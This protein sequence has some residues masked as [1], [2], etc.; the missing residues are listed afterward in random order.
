MEASD[1][2][3]LYES[4]SMCGYAFGYVHM[5]SFVLCISVYPYMKFRHMVVPHMYRF[6]ETA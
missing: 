3:R 4:M 1:I 5:F 6:A 2:M